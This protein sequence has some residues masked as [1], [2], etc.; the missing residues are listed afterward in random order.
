MPVRSVRLEASPQVIE[1]RLHRRYTAEQSPSLLWH[2]ER[3]AEL[4]QQLTDMGLDE[5][6]IWT[7]DAA[8][9]AVAQ[10]V[11]QHFGLRQAAM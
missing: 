5:V 6:C 4:T 10:Q 1:A 8:P 7:D 9:R 3:H 11:L 2:L